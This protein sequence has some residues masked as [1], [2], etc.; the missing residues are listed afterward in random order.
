MR[1]FIESQIIARRAKLLDIDRHKL[2]VE[3]ELRTFEE[4]LKHIDIPPFQPEADR[5]HPKPDR[6]ASSVPAEMT[7]GWRKVLFGLE[8]LGRTFTAADIVAIGEGAGQTPKMSNARSQI[9][10]WERKH[11]ISRVRKGKYRVAAK[12]TEII[13]KAEDPDAQTSE[14]SL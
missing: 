1:D 10:Q 8:K 7:P 6:S 2:T 11:I 9:Y 5:S 4:M 12:G 14:S 3:A 13:Q